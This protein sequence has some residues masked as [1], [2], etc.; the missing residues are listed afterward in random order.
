MSARPTSCPRDGLIPAGWDGVRRPDA[1]I[2]LGVGES[3]EYLADGYL[4]LFMGPSAIPGGWIETGQMRGPPGDRGPLGDTGPPG[5]PGERGLPG[6]TGTAGAKGDPGSPGPQG[7]RGDTGLPG[8]AGATG[9]RGDPG[10]VGEPGPEGQ[11]GP[12]G[13]Q[14][15]P[16][17]IGPVGEVGPVGPAGEQGEQGDP[18]APSFIVGDMIT[19]TAAELATAAPTGLI[20]A[21]FDGP[22]RPPAPY[23]M[24]IGEAWLNQNPADNPA[25][26]RRAIVF[27]G[28]GVL[29]TAW[30][31]ME[32]TGPQ[33][34][35]GE[36]GATGPAGPQGIPGARGATWWWA[37]QAP[38]P[39]PPIL[40]AAPGDKVLSLLADTDAPGHGNVYTVEPGGGTYNLDGN[41]RGPAGPTGP[42][43]PPGDVSWGDLIPIVTRIDGIEARVNRLES[44]QL[45]TLA[46]D[47]T[48]AD[49]SNV[50]IATVGLTD[51]DYLGS[52]H[53]TFELVGSTAIGRLI[54]AWVAAIGGAVITGPSAAQITLHSAL[55]YASLALGPFRV[56]V[57]GAPGNAVLYVRSTP[58]GGGPVGEVIVKAATSLAPTLTNAHPNASGIIAR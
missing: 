17:P 6:P 47:R 49:N 11:T 57:A 10:P 53:L 36:V 19:R 33:G 15:D 3:V 46:S 9:P 4:W 26:Y 43:G 50:I 34:D 28:L 42:Q 58:I 44:F 45:Q 54:T 22:G 5:P 41:L 18:G 16:G 32:V 38:P 23:Q 51:G 1:P 31:A 7:A 24:K 52:G 55:P 27:C 39:L 35:R 30:L 2:Q 12:P 29:T 8:A 56:L 21:G 40:G 25:L 37:G 20:P 13:E 48:L 14:G